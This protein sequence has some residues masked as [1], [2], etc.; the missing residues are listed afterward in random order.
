MS[1]RTH[2]RKAQHFN[3]RR[4]EAR[5]P[6][7]QPS[8]LNLEL[9]Q[10]LTRRRDTDH[11]S[12]APQEPMTDEREDEID[13]ELRRQTVTIDLTP[14]ILQAAGIDDPQTLT[15]RDA[16]VYFSDILNAVLVAHPEL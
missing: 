15:A 7:P 9:F 13:A 2:R 10:S 11:P 1:T 4:R 14:E 12:R 16:R 6:T 5:V 3:H 8:G